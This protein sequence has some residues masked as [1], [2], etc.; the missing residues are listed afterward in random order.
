MSMHDTGS[1]RSKLILMA[2]ATT[3]VALVTAAV[4]MLVVDARSA[5]RLWID[6]LSTQADII[7]NVAA[8]AV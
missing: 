5:Q 1:V 7:A 2:V 8:P 4:A 6:D 3:I